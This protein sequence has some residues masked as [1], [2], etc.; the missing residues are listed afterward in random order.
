M[1]CTWAAKFK[2]VH[3]HRRKIENTQVPQRAEVNNHIKYNEEHV[4]SV[5]WFEQSQAKSNDCEWF[6]L[7]FVGVVWVF[8]LFWHWHLGWKATEEAFES[9]LERGHGDLPE[10][11]WNWTALHRMRT[12]KMQQW[13]FDRVQPD[14]LDLSGLA[15]MWGFNRLSIWMIDDF[16]V[17]LGISCAV[18][19]NV[20]AEDAAVSRVPVKAREIEETH[21]T[22]LESSVHYTW[23]FVALEL[24]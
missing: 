9:E 16:S 4:W 2:G 3:F 19:D 5:L 24:E 6:F 13:S 10:Q 20:G 15:E 12:K 21:D 1:I 23:I 18:W 17:D 7:V 22:H 14:A 8:C 11:H